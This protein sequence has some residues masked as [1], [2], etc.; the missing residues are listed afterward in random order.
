MM[1]PLL[2]LAATPL[3][4]GPDTST[5]ER[6]N[7]CVDLATQDSPAAEAEAGR[8][9]MA[10]GGFF[11]HQCLGIAYANEQRWAGAAAEFEA[12]ARGAEVAKDVRSS[13]Y[14]AQAGNAWLASGDAVKARAA[15]D[16]A[17]SS[18][19][20][21]GLQRGEAY[22]DRARAFV[23]SGELDGAR[24]DL[25]L[26][27]KFADSDP[28]AWLL[29]ATLARRMD[30]LPRAK[31]DIAEALA[32]ASDDSAVQLEAGNIAALAGDELGAKAAWNQAVALKP[33]SDSAKAARAAL[34]QF[35]AP[36]KP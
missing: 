13:Q 30:E 19:T 34:K 14:W 31:K 1:L 26:A 32:R 36:A 29:S 20:L 10:G 4:A 24:S 18:S 5:E 16:A 28:L 22:L 8:W 27:L 35:E 21:A 12:A 17:I 25:D 33:D 3:Q 7:H 9:Q 23:A 15:L 11:A 2:L 6:F